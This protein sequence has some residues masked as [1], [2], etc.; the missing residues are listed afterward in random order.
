MPFHAENFGEFWLEFV[1]EGGLPEADASLRALSVT[2]PYKRVAL[3]VAGAASP[4]AEKIR[5]ANTLVCHDGVWEADSTDADGVLGPLLRRHLALRGMAAAVLGA[6]GA[7]RAAAHALA[8]AG[9]EVTLFNRGDE[10]RKRAASDLELP[11]LRWE[12]FD[13]SRFGLVVHATPLGRDPEDPLP[14]DPAGLPADGIGLDLV[15]RRGGP[16]PWVS[17]LRDCGRVGIDGREVLL[18]QAIPQFAAMTGREMPSELVAEL[19]EEMEAR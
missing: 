16:T 19:L 10:R 2:A 4:L 18:H 11:C 1:E 8:Q 14:C 13:A 17:A 7:G 6:G 3:A 12:E 9:L 5:S 15:Y